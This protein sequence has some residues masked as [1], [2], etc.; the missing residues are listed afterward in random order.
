MELL[1]ISIARRVGDTEQLYGSVTAADIAEF[2]KTKGF[3]IDR[4]KI[5]LADAIKKIQSIRAK[6]TFEMPAQ[7]LTG[8][9]E[10]L[11]GCHSHNRL[12]GALAIAV[13]RHC[14]AVNGIPYCAPGQENGSKRP[15]ERKA[16]C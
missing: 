12:A 15:A 5:Q 1:D 9:V 2:L 8:S 3:D 16:Q 10:V 6:G 7:G 4:R 13:G 11:T 14:F